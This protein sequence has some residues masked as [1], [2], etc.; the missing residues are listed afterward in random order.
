MNF[1]YEFALW[2]QIVQLSQNE[3]Y[4]LLYLNGN[5]LAI[6]YIDMVPSFSASDVYKIESESKQDIWLSVL[7]PQK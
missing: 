6:I 1:K 7:V 4:K 5:S 2:K 3:H